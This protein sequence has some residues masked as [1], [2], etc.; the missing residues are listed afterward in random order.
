MF[1]GTVKDSAALYV[2]VKATRSRGASRHREM[3]NPFKGIMDDFR[4]IATQAS[5]IGVQKEKVTK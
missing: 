5:Q 3:V 2:V 1:K 4:M